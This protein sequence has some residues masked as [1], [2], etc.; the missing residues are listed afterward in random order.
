[1]S[2]R[3]V[4]PSALVL[5]RS[6]LL[7]CFT[8]YIHNVQIMEREVKN[9]RVHL[10]TTLPPSLFLSLDFHCGYKILPP[11]P[12]RCQGESENPVSPNRHS[13]VY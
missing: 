2:F 8:Q 11:P 7:L 6:S 9:P 4:R 1:M 5:Q 13:V 10:P 3:R 12:A